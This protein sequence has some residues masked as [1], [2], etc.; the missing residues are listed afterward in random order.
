MHD[1]SEKVRRVSQLVVL[2]SLTIV[3][4]V[5]FGPLPN[6]KPLTAIFLIVLSYFSLL[7]SW[8]LMILVMVGS[9]LLFGF[10]TVVLWQ[11]LSFA[12]IQFIWWLAIGPFIKKENIPLWLQSLLAGI[13]VFLYG[14]SISFLSATQF[15][16]SPIVFWLNGLVFDSLHAAS[17]VL[18]YP[19]IDYIFRRFYK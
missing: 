19:I 15:G 17:T 18:F 12:F 11:V 9:G 8:I 4:R 16:T 10:G 2:S 13:L 5:V 14:L 7:E 6:I 3:L 1:K